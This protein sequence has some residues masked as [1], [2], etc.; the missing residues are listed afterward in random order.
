MQDSSYQV[1]KWLRSHDHFMEVRIQALEVGRAIIKNGGIS[2]EEVSQILELKH[3]RVRYLM[4]IHRNEFQKQHKEVI[5]AQK[6]RKALAFYDDVRHMKDSKELTKYRK[7]EI[8]AYE[9][10]LKEYDK[11]KYAHLEYYL[12]F[13]LR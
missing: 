12:R 3:D 8:R 5:A 1:P 6:C 7:N 2:Y 13:K 4:S 10:M 11:K 9:H